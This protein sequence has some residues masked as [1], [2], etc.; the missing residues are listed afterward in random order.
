MI[1]VAAWGGHREEANHAAT[2]L[3]KHLFGPVTLAQLSQWCACGAP[4]D[5]EATPN[6]AAKLKE[7]GLN[8]PPPPV[9]DYPLK[10][11]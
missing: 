11:W 6:L 7:S 5:L 9:M 10:T 3:D 8:W 4:F 1:M 2:M